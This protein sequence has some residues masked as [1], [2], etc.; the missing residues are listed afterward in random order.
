MPPP[1]APRVTAPELLRALERAGWIRV[2]QR[3]GHVHLRHP[4]RGSRV[5]IPVHAGR[6]LRPATLA[7]ILVQSALTYDELRELL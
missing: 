2:G 5:T 7:S 4:D 1:R 6:T 3:G